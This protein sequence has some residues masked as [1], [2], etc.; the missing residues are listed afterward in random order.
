MN[1]WVRGICEDI[2][3][4]ENMKVEGLVRMWEKEDMRLLKERIVEE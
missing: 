4:L 3:N 2:R 1:R